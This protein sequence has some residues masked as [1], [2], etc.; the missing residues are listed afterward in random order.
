MAEYTPDSWV[1]IKMTH[2]SKTFYK[3][4][5]GWTGGYTQGSSW[6]LSSTIEKCEYD[7]SYD[8][9]LFYN[10]SG[11][12]YSVNPDSYGLRMSTIGVWEQ[13][14]EKY[15]DQVELL[16]SCDWLAKVWKEKKAAP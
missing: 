15:P 8:R 1:V 5:G 11:S 6:R 9:L 4:L 3:V 14:K 16:E 10:K 7:I 2:S 13:M 12:I